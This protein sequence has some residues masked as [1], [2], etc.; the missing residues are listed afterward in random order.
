[1]EGRIMRT[2]V[3]GG[4]RMERMEEWQYLKNNNFLHLLENMNS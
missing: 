4:E 2:K 1:M 3:L